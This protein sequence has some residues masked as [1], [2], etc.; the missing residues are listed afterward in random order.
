MADTIHTAPARPAGSAPPARQE[1]D[2]RPAAGVGAD[3]APASASPA[4]RDAATPA[5][6]PVQVRTAHWA[7]LALPLMAV[8]VLM[9]GLLVLSDV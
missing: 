4:Q 5:P 8:M 9:I 7:P 6:L 1:T 2:S 3:D